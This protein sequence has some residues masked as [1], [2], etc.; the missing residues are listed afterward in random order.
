MKGT[1]RHVSKYWRQIFLLRFLREFV[2][3]ISRLLSLFNLLKSEYILLYCSA[4]FSLST[5]KSQIVFR[6]VLQLYSNYCITKNPTKIQASIIH[7]LFPV[8]CCENFGHH[9]GMDIQ[10]TPIRFQNDQTELI[11]VTVTSYHYSICGI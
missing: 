3:E 6:Y 7:R 5:Q 2:E 11:L 9:V 1:E 8:V 4:I 10:P